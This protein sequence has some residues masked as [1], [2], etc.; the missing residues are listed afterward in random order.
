MMVIGLFGFAFVF[1]W[2]SGKKPQY[3]KQLDIGFAGQLP[4]SAEEV[5]FAGNFFNPYR[6]ALA[7]LPR[8]H[9]GRIFK[10]ITGIVHSLGDAVRA[11]FTG[12][13]R[14]YLA[15]SLIFLILLVIWMRGGI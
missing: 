11:I 5:H 15:H 12:D 9:A 7:F 4:P 3:V 8:V 13:T 1:C 10:G 2:M 14:T 6:R